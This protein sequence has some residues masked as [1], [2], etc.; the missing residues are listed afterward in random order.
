MNTRG[1]CGATMTSL[2]KRVYID[3]M[4]TFESQSA[5]WMWRATD[6]PSLLTSLMKRVYIDVTLTFESQSA[7]Q[8]WRAT[9]WPSLLTSAQ[10]TPPLAAVR[11]GRRGWRR[12]ATSA[13]PA[14]RRASLRPPISTCGGRRQPPNRRRVRPKVHFL[15][16]FF[17]HWFFCT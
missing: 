10:A 5:I 4:L 12:P 11:R 16:Y 6:W 17:S 15:H 3:V 8:M 7:I 14:N 2:M 9:D 13:T 1:V